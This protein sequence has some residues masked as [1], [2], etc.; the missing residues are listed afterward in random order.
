VLQI[1][2]KG[3]AKWGKGSECEEK[4]ETMAMDEV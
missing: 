2:R 1:L 3:M 4:T